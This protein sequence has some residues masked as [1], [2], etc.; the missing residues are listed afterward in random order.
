MAPP[1]HENGAQFLIV[2]V[3]TDA[4]IAGAGEANGAPRWSGETVWGAK[5]LVDEILAPQI[6][7][8]DPRDIVDINHRMD[9]VCKHNWFTKAAL[10]M[11]CWDIHGRAQD[12]PVYELLGGPKRSQVVRGRFGMGAYEPN[13]AHALAVELVAAGFETIKVKVG[14]EP[15]VDIE[16]VRVVRQVLGPDGSLVI[17]GTGGWDADTAIDCVKRLED[18]NIDWVEQPTPA[19]DYAAL[20]RVRVETGRRIMAD[21]ACFDL[22]A[23]QTLLGY[24]CC[25]GLSVYPGKNGGISKAM[26][27]AE[28]AGAQGIPCTIGSNLELDIATAAMGHLVLGCE[29]LAVER[30]PGDMRGPDQYEVSIV[31]NPI[32]I[33]GPLTTV[34]EGPGLGVEVDWDLVRSLAPN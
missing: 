14:G 11:A 8:A 18:C 24:R 12:K 33:E 1:S 32:R 15:A 9:R 25:D 7:G 19:G 27:I 10:E 31:K 16:R 30:N 6:C 17:D 4:G 26:G 2:R 22:L 5:A 13:M 34:P 21:D 20:A 3:L 23:A 29:N 28:M